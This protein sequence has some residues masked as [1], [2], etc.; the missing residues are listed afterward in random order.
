MQ[1]AAKHGYRYCEMQMHDRN[2]IPAFAKLPWIL[3]R[4]FMRCERD[5]QG[6]HSKRRQSVAPA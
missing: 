4:G 3:V 6:S 1:Y 5:L 2:K